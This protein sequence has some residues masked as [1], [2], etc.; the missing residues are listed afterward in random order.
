MLEGSKLEIFDNSGR[1]EHDEEIKKYD[2]IFFDF[3]NAIQLCIRHEA[4]LTKTRHKLAF[5][6]FTV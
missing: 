5:V 2:H 6:K 4:Q 1:L 3:L